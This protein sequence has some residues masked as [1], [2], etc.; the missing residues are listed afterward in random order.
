MP[1]LTFW[2]PNRA[3]MGALQEIIAERRRQD[4]KWGQ[5]DHSV[6]EW[7][8]ILAEEFGEAA[9]AGNHYY[10]MKQ[11]ESFDLDTLETW[12]KNYRQ[13]LIET[14]AVCIAA[15]ENLDRHLYE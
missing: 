12:K 4:E 6:V 15:I 7:V 3:E 13:E 1:S 11:K 5:Q 14:A 8:S 9:R 10:F 2:T